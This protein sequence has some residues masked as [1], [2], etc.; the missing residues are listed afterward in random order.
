[1]EQTVVVCGLGQ[2]GRRVVDFLAS[3]GV[4][5]V[6]VDTHPEHAATLPPGMKFV[7]G[8]C[9]RPDVLQQA[10]IGQVRGVLVVTSDDL[11]NITTAL[12]VRQLNP[13][14]RIVVRM[15]NQ[16]LIAR[17]GASV[18]NT[19]ALSVSA[20]TAPFL[21]MSA[22]TGDSLGGF[23]LEEGP[24]Q[25]ME[26]V[27]T[28]SSPLVNRRVSEV[29]GQY[30]WLVLGYSS[31]TGQ[32]K[33]LEEIPSDIRLSVGDVL[34]VCGSA[35]SMRPFCTDDSSSLDGVLWAGRLKRLSRTVRRTLAEV[36]LPVKIG[37]SLILS[38]MLLGTLVFNLGLGT[39]WQDGLYQTVS[40]IA[41]G[42][43]LHGEGRPEWAKVFLSILKISG[44]G[45]VAGFTAIVTQYLVR[46][47]LGGAFEVAKIPDGG[48]VVVCGLGNVGFRVVEELLKLGRSVVAI[49]KATDNNYAATVRRMGVPVVTGDATVP[50]VLKQARCDTARAVITTAD[51]ELVNLEIA[52]L[53]RELNAKQRV[54][55]RLND[56]N[57]AEAV[58][59]AADIKL[60]LAIP[61]LAAPAF[62]AAL[63]GDRVLT[64]VNLFNK[65][66]AIIEL[67]ITAEDS[68]FRDTLLQVGM[69][70][71]RFLPLAVSGRRSFAVEGIP[72]S[73]R[74]QAGD[75]LTVLLA[76]RDLEKLLRR[77]S[78][79]KNCRVTVESHP[80]LTAEALMTLV[81]T[82]RRCTQAEAEELLKRPSFELAT[83]LTRGQ[84]EELAG[85][86]S[87]EK[88]KVRV[89][90]TAIS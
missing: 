67:T 36:D 3:A 54:V 77:E 74:L 4:P 73:Y 21:A 7:T 49:E 28:E 5:V 20:L 14:C 46:A 27:V 81:R 11:V 41:T 59:D 64:L 60:A 66:Y 25:I 75:R 15:F 88:A 34:A 55:V 58:R 23:P 29:A 47:K 2:V 10:N 72:S 9:R 22:L 42:A 33:R 65:P 57:F 18:K 90:V 76:I 61:S 30:Q 78:I 19:T 79:P 8:D 17:L 69:I 62:A 50:T 43:D 13:Q 48:H 83:G 40:I 35:A 56:E 37:F 6:V 45:I 1:V 84:A 85:R 68:I 86:V 53:V 51:A 80:M 12:L 44:L 87:R 82:E 70:D 38:T 63:F 32:V 39:T 71:Y 24:Q 26:V 16:N 89:D 31:S 52:L